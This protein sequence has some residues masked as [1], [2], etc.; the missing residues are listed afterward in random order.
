MSCNYCHSAIIFC[1]LKCYVISLSDQE[2]E[3]HSMRPLGNGMFTRSL[4]NLK[5]K[6]SNMYVLSL[7]LFLKQLVSSERRKR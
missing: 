6:V 7:P 3:I 4:I 5:F 1:S 2:I